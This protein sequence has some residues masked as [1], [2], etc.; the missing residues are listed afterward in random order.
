M[1][2]EPVPDH[3]RTRAGCRLPAAGSFWNFLVHAQAEPCPRI[4]G[5]C[6]AASAQKDHARKETGAEA[7]THDQSKASSLMEGTFCIVERTLQTISCPI[8]WVALSCGNASEGILSGIPIG[9]LQGR[10]VID[11]IS[12]YRFSSFSLIFIDFHET[13]M[14]W[15]KNQTEMIRE[16]SRTSLKV[17]LAL[18]QPSKIYFLNT[19]LI[20]ELF[21]MHTYRPQLQRSEASDLKGCPDLMGIIH[22]SQAMTRCVRIHTR[23]WELLRNLSIA[24]WILKQTDNTLVQNVDEILCLI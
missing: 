15:L 16:Y 3:C 18:K 24:S 5:Q 11:S 19:N 8:Y 14:N 1:I 10:E 17:V 4:S 6:L 21:R 23:L 2:P 9:R 12:Q 13:S 7:K 20:T 22:Q